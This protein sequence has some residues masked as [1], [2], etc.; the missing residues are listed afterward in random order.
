M[1]VYDDIEELD[2]FDIDNIVDDICEVCFY[3]E[4]HDDDCPLSPSNRFFDEEISI[5]ED[6]G[7]L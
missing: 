6:E 4:G 7:L 5:A 1:G 2:V 3:D